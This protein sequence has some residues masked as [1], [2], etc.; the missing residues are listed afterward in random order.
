MKDNA[1]IFADRQLAY[2][3]ELMKRSAPVSGEAVAA[4]RACIRFCGDL[5]EVMASILAEV[6]AGKVEET[7]SRWICEM[8]AAVYGD[9]ASAVQ[10]VK[11]AGK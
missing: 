3:D 1:R 8:S 6:P 4:Q 7:V 11:G 10:K 5:Q 2:F 9:G